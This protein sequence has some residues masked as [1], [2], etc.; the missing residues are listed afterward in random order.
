MPAPVGV[1]VR[2]GAG[3]FPFPAWVAALAMAA[4]ACSSQAIGERGATA[5]PGLTSET[6]PD[7]VEIPA[8]PFV[9]GADQAHD[10]MAFENERW[11][12]ASGEGTVDV[13]AFYLARHEVTVDQFSAF[14]R[15]TSWPVDAR[16]LAAPPAHPVTFVS[17]PDALA[18]CRWMSNSIEHSPT[19]PPRLR[20]LRRAG[21]RVM[22]P[23]EAEWEKAARGT[24][25]RRYPWGNEPQRSRA[26]YEGTGTVPVGQ[27]GCSEC[28]HGLL[29]MS[30][31]VW[32]WTSSPY[33]PYP[34]DPSDDAANLEA[35]ALWVIRGGHYGDGPRLVRTTTRGAADPGA[36]RAFIGFRVALSQAP[37]GAK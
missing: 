8:G 10:P 14:V 34:Y 12:P 5:D 27:F 6:F 25:R 4:S 2:K 36:R 17:W 18:Y 21:W 20:E 11:S 32:E 26:N 16:A 24:D 3:F 22:L 29:D 19:T 7:F 33:Q 23:S 30:G 15:A 35:D 31:N 13:P 37:A 9:M 28:S 1:A